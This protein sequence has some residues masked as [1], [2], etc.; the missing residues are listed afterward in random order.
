[1]TDNFALRG[2]VVAEYP[3]ATRLVDEAVRLEIQ[4]DS[5]D[6]TLDDE[7]ALDGALDNTLLLF[8]GAE[9]LSAFDLTLVDTGH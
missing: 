8:A 1:V 2:H 5:A 7:L 4:F 3:A 6:K 9:I